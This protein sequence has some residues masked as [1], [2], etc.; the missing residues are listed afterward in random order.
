MARVTVTLSGNERQ[1]LV[2]FAKAEL[3]DPRA[4]AALIL[5]RALEEAGF[6]PPIDGRATF[7]NGGGLEPAHYPNSPEVTR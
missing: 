3:R 2:E 4:Q 1:A 6:L 7:D 5:R